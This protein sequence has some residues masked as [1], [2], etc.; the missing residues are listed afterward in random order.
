MP[1]MECGHTSQGVS[2]ATQEPV[3]II[4]VGIHPGARIVAA[5]PDLSGREAC[6]SYRTPG[7]Y[8]SR[9]VVRDGRHA[10][11]KSDTNLAFFERREDQPF[12]EYYCGCFG[13]D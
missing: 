13:W 2:S 10:W 8:G 4:C 1:F 9:E 5:E 7:R 6:C 12:D 11:V 3:C